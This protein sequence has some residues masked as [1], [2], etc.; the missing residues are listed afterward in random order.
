MEPDKT[1]KWHL[2]LY[3]S[4]DEEKTDKTARLLKEICDE[5]LAGKC[6]IEVVD[7]MTNPQTAAKE[8]IIATP[9]LI[10]KYPPPTKR[11]IGDLTDKKKLLKGLGIEDNGL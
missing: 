10:K 6:E 3:A 7:I 2:C 5:N 9:C 1:M 8:N 4:G 11:L